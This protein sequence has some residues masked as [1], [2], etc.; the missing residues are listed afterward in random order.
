[1]KDLN[2]CYAVSFDDLETNIQQQALDVAKHYYRNNCIQIT[3]D[4]NP[5][6][7]STKMSVRESKTELKLK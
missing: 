7:D 5:M 1:M 6:R 2:K 4:V 3:I